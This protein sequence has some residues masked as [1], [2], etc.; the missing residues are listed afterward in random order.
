M[1]ITLDLGYKVLNILYILNILNILGILNILIIDVGVSHISRCT[2]LVNYLYKSLRLQRFMTM[3][4]LVLRLDSF[5][6]NRSKFI[7]DTLYRKLEY[8]TERKHVLHH[9]DWDFPQYEML[10]RLYMYKGE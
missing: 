6:S 3:I 4:C 5:T 9:A 8:K 1:V 2:Y 7:I 10:I